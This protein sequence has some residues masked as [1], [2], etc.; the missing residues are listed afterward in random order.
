MSQTNQQQGGG[1]GEILLKALDGGSKTQIPFERYL[2]FFLS[3]NYTILEVET[4]F[5]RRV[6]QLL[7]K[8][9]RRDQTKKRHVAAA[10]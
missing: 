2:V 3:P 5:F 10:R 6:Q 8:E 9:K 1:V 7:G 4:R